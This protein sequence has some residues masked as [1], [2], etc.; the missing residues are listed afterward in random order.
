MCE[1]HVRVEQVPN[2]FVRE[3]NCTFMWVQSVFLS[4]SYT[5]STRCIPCLLVDQ[6]L[7]LIQ[8]TIRHA[9]SYLH[10]KITNN[11]KPTTATPSIARLSR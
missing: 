7:W 4:P 11:M 10:L 3:V 6:P 9:K 2:V 8:V 5:K 1:L